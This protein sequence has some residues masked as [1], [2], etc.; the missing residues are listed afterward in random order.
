MS[1]LFELVLKEL[2]ELRMVQTDPNFANYRYRPASGE[3]VLL[4]F[5]ATRE[6]KAGFVNNYKRLAKAAIAGDEGRVAAAAEKLGYAVGEAGSDYR[7][8]I[9]EL[10]QLA[11]EP[12][13]EDVE[14]DFAN[15]D[16]AANLSVLSEDLTGYSEFWQA[17]HTDALYFHRKLGGM[18]LLATRLEA[19]V[20]LHRLITSLL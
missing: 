17:P 8:L 4:D 16:M 19:R 13:R 20:N 14:Y 3:I 18:Y 7:A 1:A 5:G 11:L 2:F 12:V 9:M 15:S 6:F 10:F